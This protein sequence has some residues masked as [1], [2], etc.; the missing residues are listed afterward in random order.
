MLLLNE[1][2]FINQKIPWYQHQPR[3][4]EEN[5]RVK[6][7]WNFRIQTDHRLKHIKPDIVVINKLS[8]EANIIDVAIP[9]DYKITQ[10]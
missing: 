10:K 5:E 6:L 9:N 2:D 3:A 1:Y 7:L 4:V 8:N